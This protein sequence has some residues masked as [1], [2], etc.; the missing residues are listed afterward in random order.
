[1]H[2]TNES[3]QACT[4]DDEDDDDSLSPLGPI[5]IHVD[6]SITIDGQSNTIVLPPTNNAN[7][8]PSAQSSA[9]PMSQCRTTA[10]AR[11]ARAESLTSTIMTALTD[12]GVMGGGEGEEPGRRQRPLELHVN[13]SVNVKGERNA[14]CAGIPRTGRKNGSATVL[15]EQNAGG[16]VLEGGEVGKLEGS[17]KRRAESVSAC[18]A[19]RCGSN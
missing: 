14:I 2:V 11:N 5:T 13:A 10:P 18:E 15:Q 6:A 19:F 17:R 7:T 9:G 8:A 12:A 4:T 1:M 3:W 16:K